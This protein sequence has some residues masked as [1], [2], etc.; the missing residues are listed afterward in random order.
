MASALPLFRTIGHQLLIVALVI[1]SL[2]IVVRIL[3]KLRLFP[4]GCY[5]VATKLFWPRWATAHRTACI[6]LF[7]ACILLFIACILFFAVTWIVHFVRKR[8]EEQIMA[9]LIHH[10]TKDLK[11]GESRTLEFL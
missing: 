2:P 5:F 3:W 10:Y 7:I 1:L 9:E 11:P 8:R 6:L 4:L